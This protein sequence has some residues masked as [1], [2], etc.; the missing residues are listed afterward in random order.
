TVSKERF[1]LMEAAVLGVRSGDGDFQPEIELVRPGMAGEAYVRIR[2]C[3]L[4]GEGQRRIYGLGGDC[5]ASINTEDYGVTVEEAGPLRAGIAWHAKSEAN[6]PAGPYGG[7][8]PFH[9]TTRLHAYAGH[10][11]LRVLHTLVV[12][13]NPRE[14]EV[15]EIGLHVPISDFGFR[16]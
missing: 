4:D 3:F 2:E 11:H 7:Y 13:C 6:I 16:I 12:A 9:F 15:E 8:R 5:R 1:S 14:T 10:T